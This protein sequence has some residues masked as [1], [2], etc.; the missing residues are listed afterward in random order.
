MSQDLGELSSNFKPNIDF[1][2]L[3]EDWLLNRMLFIAGPRQ[4]GKTSYV[5]KKLS[6]MGGTY[7]NW[8]DRKVSLA[9]KKNPDFFVPL[10]ERNNLVIFDEIHKKS[11]WKDILKGV[12]DVYKNDY[13]FVVTGSARLDTFRRSGDSL[14]G[15]YFLTHIFPL[16][17]KDLALKD[18]KEF[19]DAMTLIREVRDQQA[20]LTNDDH[21]TLINLSGFPEP[22]FSGSASVLRRWQKQHQEL[23]IREDLRDLTRIQD[24]DGV[25][26]MIDLLKLKVSST[27][28]YNSLV[29]DLEVDH[30]TIKRWIQQVERM[31]MFFTIK[32]WYK[33]IQN[34]MKKNPKIYF[35]DW[36]VVQDPGARFE[37]FIAMQIYKTITLWNDRFGHNFELF[38][39]RTYD[40]KEIDFCVCLDSKPWL[41]IEV[42]LG[43]PQA[44]SL[45]H[46]I[47]QDF[48]IPALVLT[49]EPNWNHEK[50]GIYLMDYRKFLAVLA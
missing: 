40:D 4:V 21:E 19:I 32:P 42:K 39:I 35:Y 38:F 31:M 24:L 45:L 2:S 46:K 22:F 33:K 18:F 30:K 8:D 25:S 47:K 7:F 36:T 28:S 37:N 26:Y 34:S 13:C 14:V 5:K 49:K 11:K 17:I 15:R 16:S 9:Y 20:L 3:T 41:L 48:N 6:E 23:L 1:F 44:S 29:E 10:S 12:Y 27:C 50:D 43:K